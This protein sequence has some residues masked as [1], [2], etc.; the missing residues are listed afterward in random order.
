MH[1]KS[2]LFTEEFRENIYNYFNLQFT[3]TRDIKDEIKIA[4]F[5][6]RGGGHWRSA[7]EENE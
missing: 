2:N 5:G 7:P 3:Q 6:F 1:N 4:K